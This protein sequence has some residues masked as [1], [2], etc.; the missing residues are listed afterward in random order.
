MKALHGS[1]PALVLAPFSIVSSANALLSEPALSSDAFID[2]IG[3]NIQVAVTDPNSP[4]G[5]N[6][7]QCVINALNQSRI[8]HVRVFLHSM[9]SEWDRLLYIHDSTNLQVKAD[10]CLTPDTFLNATT[11]PRGNTLVADWGP[12]NAYRPLKSYLVHRNDPSLQPG[13]TGYLDAIE[14]MEGLNETSCHTGPAAAENPLYN[15][16]ADPT[17]YHASNFQPT[18][19]ISTMQNAELNSLRLPVNPPLD[20]YPPSYL[21]LLAPSTCSWS[22]GYPEETQ[23][24]EQ[25]KTDFDQDLPLNYLNMHSY[26]D[27]A[28]VPSAYLNEN[29]A[30][31]RSISAVPKPIRVTET[32]YQ[33]SISSNP[34]P[35]P[36]ISWRAQGIYISRLLA[37]YAQQYGRSRTPIQRVYLYELFDDY[38]MSIPSANQDPEAYYGLLNYHNKPKPAFTALCGLISLLEDPTQKTNPTTPLG[39][40]QFSISSSL[41]NETVPPTIQHLVLQK[42]DGAYFILLWNNLSCYRPGQLY[43]DTKNPWVPLNLEFEQPL[44]RCVIHRFNEA[45]GRRIDEPFPSGKSAVQVRIHDA[46]TIVEAKL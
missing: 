15:Y 41:K 17:Q 5:H 43:G 20:P 37:T 16:A 40:L 2:T 28:T 34:G 26:P 29:V 24:Y 44:T 25:Y 42:S 13:W 36:L 32:G 12:G 35:Q 45:T 21:P 14:M 27:G 10:I 11:D 31:A 39:T 1:F 6:N 19:S 3:V 9:H 7:G 30:V 33:T 23:I 18:L 38:P 8:R 22:P 4:Y 46:L